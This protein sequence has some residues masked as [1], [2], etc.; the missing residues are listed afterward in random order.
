MLAYLLDGDDIPAALAAYSQARHARTDAISIRARRA[1][2]VAA[3]T[4]PVAIAARDFAVRATPARA[5]R[6]AMDNLFD[7]FSLPAAPAAPARTQR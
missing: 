2:R 4:H 5:A 1:G 7:G 3:L 6:R